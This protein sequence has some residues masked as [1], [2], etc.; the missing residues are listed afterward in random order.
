M[1]VG[2]WILK[3]D[4]WCCSE[5]TFREDVNS[6]WAIAGIRGYYPGKNKTH[7]LEMALCYKLAS[8]FHPSLLVAS[9]FS[10]SAFRDSVLCD[11]LPCYQEG[12]L[13]LLLFNVIGKQMISSGVKALRLIYVVVPNLSWI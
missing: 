4:S 7:F 6:Q 11:L 3:T 12:S 1:S 8:V 9:S 13:S 10:K 5:Q 2:L